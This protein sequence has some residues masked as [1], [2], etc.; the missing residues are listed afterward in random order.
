MDEARPRPG[1]NAKSGQPRSGVIAKKAG[2]DGACCGHVL[3]PTSSSVAVAAAVGFAV[4]RKRR[5][6]GLL[7]HEG[8]NRLHRVG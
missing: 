4:R 5:H 1:L 3:D 8:E 6:S 7:C 2:E